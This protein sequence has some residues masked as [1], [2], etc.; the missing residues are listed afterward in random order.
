MTIFDRT[1]ILPRQYSIEE[2][3]KKKILQQANEEAFYVSDL[4]TVIRQHDQWTRLCP[5]VEPF[6]AVKC[7]NDPALLQTLAI[8]GTGFDCASRAEI[9]AVLALGVSPDRIIFA[10]PCKMKSHIE[11]ARDNKVAM[12]TF[13]DEHEML[14]IKEYYPD[15]K[16]VIR[17]L[18]PPSK[19][20][21]NLGCKY[22]I[23]PDRAPALVR[24]AVEMKMNLVGVSFHVGS[25]C[26][27]A[28]A[29]SKAIRAV[30]KVFQEAERL[31]LDLEILDIGGGF[32]GHEQGDISF[33]EISGYINS[34]L[35][36]H[37]QKHGNIRVIAEPGRYFASAAYTLVTNIIGKRDNMY[38]IN[39]GVYGSFNCLLY[40]HAIVDIK[41]LGRDHEDDEVLED[42]SVWGPTCDGLDCVLTSVA[43][44]NLD[45]G[46]W[47]YFPN[48]GAYTLAAGSTFNGMPRPN[49]CHVIEGDLYD[50][51]KSLDVDVEEKTNDVESV[52][53]EVSDKELLSYEE[54]YTISY[55]SGKDFAMPPKM[56]CREIC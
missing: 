32:P 30:S 10:N 41:L 50:M 27:E 40:D 2:L 14:K 47:V 51:L 52:S 7:N 23:D 18:P 56:I 53:C 49:T 31:G 1:D 48:M 26:L 21:C 12:M 16:L 4:G 42:S 11:F 34:S 6:Y 44:P 37:F 19:A 9:E 54:G 36:E 15:A 8:L 43:L 55:K 45:I 39:D 29:F 22:G 17:I 38:Y 25:G 3:I 33:A 35:A 46:D 5:G 13:D 28:D 20:Q 24:R